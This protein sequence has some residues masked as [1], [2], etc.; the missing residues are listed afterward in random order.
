[1]SNF[2]ETQLAALAGTLTVPVMVNQVESHPLLP[3]QKLLEYCRAQ[4]IIL[5]AY[6]PLGSPDNVRARKE[7]DPSLLGNE[8]IAAIGKSY[9]KSVAQVLI[10]FHTQRGVVAIPKSKTPAYIAANLHTF[11]FELSDAHLAELVSME[12][13]FRYGPNGGAKDHPHFPWPEEFAATS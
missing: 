3:Q 11:D 6:S 8:R 4:K 2:S 1:M 9:G 13:P 12:I 5:T 10:R 7:S